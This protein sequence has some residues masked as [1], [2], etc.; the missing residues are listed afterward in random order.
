MKS[1]ITAAMPVHNAEEFLE[2]ALES[3]ARQTRRPDRVIVIDNCSTDST[4]EIAKNFRGIPVEYTRNSQD[5][6]SFGNFNRC[7]D[8]AAETDLLH[9]LHADDLIKP[10]FYETMEPLLE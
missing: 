8:Y 2:Q 5:L 6:D 7:L 3:V 4:P 10:T 9:I 1:I